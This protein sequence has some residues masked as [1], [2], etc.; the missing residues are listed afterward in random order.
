VPKLAEGASSITEPKYPTPIGAKGE[1]AEVSKVP[2]TES[3]EALKR[4]AEAKGK[5]VEEPELEESAGLPKIL[6]PPPEPELPKVSKAP[7]ITPKRRRMASVL[8]AILESTRAPTPASANEAEAEAGPS[9]PIEIGLVETRQNIEQGPSD[10]ALA[11]EKE[12][13]PK[14][15]EFPSPE[16]S[17]EELDFIIRHTLGKK[18]SEEE[19]AEAK[20]YVKELKY[21]KGSL[22][23]NGT[24]EDDFLYCLPDNKELSVCR[25]MARNIGFPK[26]EVGLSA[27]SKDDLADSLAYD[28]LKVKTF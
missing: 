26:L 2:A 13:A 4:P 11:L 24:G 3:T 27:M 8:D 9:V 25:E 1:L 20:H 19:I 12:D 7:A 22:V 16:A 15:V 18:L 14:K 10:A 21:P 28:S 17:T 5:A 6:S 23:Y